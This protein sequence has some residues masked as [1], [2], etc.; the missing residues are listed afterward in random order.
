MTLNIKPNV[1]LDNAKYLVQELFDFEV[2]NVQ[3]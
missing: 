1:D 3:V 2:L